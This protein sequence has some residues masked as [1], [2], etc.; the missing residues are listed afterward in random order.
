MNERISWVQPYFWGNEIAYVND[1][2]K[3]TWISG[4]SYIKKLEDSFSD[5][6]NINN[7]ITTSNGTTSIHLAY[8]AVGIKP[9]DEIIVPGFAF[10]AAA[11]IALHFGAKPIFADVDPKTW[12]ITASEIEKKITKKTKAI[13]PVHTYGNVCDMD[14]IMNIANKYNIWVIEDVA[15][16]LFSKYKDKYAGTFGHLSSFSFQAT[17]TIT[18]GEGGMLI[19]ANKELSDKMKLYRSHGLS[20][21]GKYWHEVPGH[22]FRLTNMQAALGV[23]QFEKRNDI[24]AARKNMHNLYLKNLKNIDEIELQYFEPNINPVLWAFALKISKKVFP[25][26][27]DILIEQLKEAGIETRPGFIA[28]SRLK[29]FHTHNVP[30][31]EM[32]GDAVIS[33][34]SVPTLNEEKIYFICNQ[35]LKLKK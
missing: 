21:R 2:V 31:S 26:G 30:V 7:S 3:S 33:L 8:L 23:A 29:I 5:L 12:N 17:K 32:L 35:L 9:G 25:Q 15:E 11:N 1:A 4:G 20:E 34:P 6:F 10:M 19:T 13:V 27:R 14:E 24:I 16:A 18:T 28:S 22:N